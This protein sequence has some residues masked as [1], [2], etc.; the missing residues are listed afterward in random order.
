MIR[1]RCDRTDW[2]GLCALVS[3]LRSRSWRRRRPHVVASL[4]SSIRSFSH[5]LQVIFTTFNKAQVLV[6]N[7][8]VSFGTHVISDRYPVC[9]KVRHIP[10]EILQFGY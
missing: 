8:G 1:C 5:L 2:G 7:H 10:V 4:L 3:S 6:L 9:A